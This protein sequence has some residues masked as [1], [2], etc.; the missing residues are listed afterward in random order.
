MFRP[1]P[2]ANGSRNVL[3]SDKYICSNMP[4][5]QRSRV[6]VLCQPQRASRVLTAMKLKN[7]ALS[8]M[9]SAA[10]SACVAV[11]PPRHH[12]VVEVVVRPPAPRVIVV[13]AAR[14]GYVWAPG[15][16]QWNG[17]AHVW[18]EGRYIRARP[19]ERWVPAHW[20][21]FRPG[22]WRFEEGRWER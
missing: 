2:A 11:P 13:P 17:R 3:A 12:T 1:I 14:H 8:I 5:W 19:N 7:V 6:R 10:L 20:E 15:F 18:V 9:I 22:H 4:H 16:W 21:E